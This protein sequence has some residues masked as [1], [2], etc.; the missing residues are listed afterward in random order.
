MLG[1]LAMLDGQGRSA[2]AVADRDCVVHL[3][4]REALADLAVSDPP[5]CTLLYRNIAMHL[6]TRLRVASEAWNGAAA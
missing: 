3:L 5:L 1:E 4:S 6:A 2:M